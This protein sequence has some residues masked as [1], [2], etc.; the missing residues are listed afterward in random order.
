MLLYREYF[1]LFVGETRRESD[2]TAVL[3]CE[4]R[5]ELARLRS[6]R[7]RFAFFTGRSR[8]ACEE[9]CIDLARPRMSGPHVA[10]VLATS[11]KTIDECASGGDPGCTDVANRAFSDLPF[12]SARPPS[13]FSC[14]Q[15]A[16]TRTKSRSGLLPVTS[17]ALRAPLPLGRPLPPSSIGNRKHEIV[18]L[19]PR[20]LQLRDQTDALPEGRDPVPNLAQRPCRTMSSSYAG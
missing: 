13:A 14:S 16:F 12:T 17:P 3:A 11:A 1:G 7:E 2:R 5:W 19:R 20:R 4:T 10:S 15:S 18:R 9:W 6:V 8:P